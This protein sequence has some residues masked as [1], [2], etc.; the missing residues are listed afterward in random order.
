MLTSSPFLDMESNESIPTDVGVAPKQEKDSIISPHQVPENMLSPP[1]SRSNSP[2]E[3]MKFPDAPSK[4]E[5]TLDAEDLKLQDI[6][7]KEAEKAQE[8]VINY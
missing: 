5:F 1:T 8:K 3:D 2:V 7:Q 6:K 4:E